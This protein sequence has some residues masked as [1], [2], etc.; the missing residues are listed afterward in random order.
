MKVL[1]LKNKEGEFVTEDTLQKIWE[2]RDRAGE[3]LFDHPSLTKL[4]Q[5]FANPFGPPATVW[6]MLGAEAAKHGYE[7]GVAEM[8]E[9]EYRGLWKEID[10]EFELPEESL[11][12]ALDAQG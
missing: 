2:G 12:D 6:L 1:T 4:N 11:E 10:P 9:D 3:N 5:A 7:F 8:T